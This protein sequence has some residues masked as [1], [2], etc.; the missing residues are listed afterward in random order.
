MITMKHVANMAMTGIA[1]GALAACGAPD[2]N[3]NR[4]IMPGETIGADDVV[5]LPDENT[6]SGGGFCTPVPEAGAGKDGFRCPAV[7][8]P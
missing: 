3:A 8:T 4:E 6:P 1:A 7:P 2:D 5:I